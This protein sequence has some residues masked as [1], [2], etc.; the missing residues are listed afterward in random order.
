MTVI[1]DGS[2]LSIRDVVNV[3]RNY[4]QVEIKPVALEKMN[5]CRKLI[6]KIISEKKVVYGVSTGFGLMSE[7]SITEDEIDLLQYNLVVS[8]CTGVG[9]AFCRGS[10]Q[11][12]AFTQGMFFSWRLLRSQTAYCQN[13]GRNVK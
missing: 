8:C 7:V 10:S 11:G 4:E 6:E 13:Y 12:Y 2:S 9:R 5:S 3:S 1:I